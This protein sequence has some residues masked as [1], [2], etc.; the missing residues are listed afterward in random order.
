MV[1]P[2]TGEFPALMTFFTEGHLVDRPLLQQVPL[3]PDQVNPEMQ[4]TNW[5]LDLHPAEALLGNMDFNILRP[6]VILPIQ[7]L[8]LVQQTSLTNLWRVLVLAQ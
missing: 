7:S 1:D 8:P 6:L 3:Y 2:T 4:L 5:E